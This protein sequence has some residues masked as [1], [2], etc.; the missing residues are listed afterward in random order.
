MCRVALVLAVWLVSSSG[1]L[2]IAAGAEA[3]EELLIGWQGETYRPKDENDKLEGA[4]VKPSSPDDS[5]DSER[6]IETI[7]W[8]PRAFLFHNFLSLDEVNHIVKLV[9]DR[10]ARSSVVDTETGH[11]KLDPIRTS[12]GSS[13]G[14]GQDAVIAAIETRMA[15]W[16]RL[17]PSH[18]EPIQVL[19]YQDGQKYGA[20]WDW[21]DDPIHKQ[22]NG[23]NRVATILMYLGDVLEGGETSFP[24]AIPINRTKQSLGSLS[25]CAAR[26]NLAV[27][28]HKGDAVLFW[29]ILPDGITVDRKALH[30]SCPIIKGTKWTATKWIHNRPYGET[31]D[32][33]QKA[34]ECLD[35]NHQCSQ[36][37]KEGKCDSDAANMLGLMGKCRL[38]CQDCVQCPRNDVIC[39]RQN[40]RSMR[41]QRQKGDQDIQ[42]ALKSAGKALH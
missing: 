7:S 27:R 13:I 28:P 39:L 3:K 21:F 12:Y 31:Y 6:W 24:L 36:W 26:G 40:M 29:D 2:G 34:A 37:A 1:L 35:R 16:T 11:H 18:G 23:E 17:P 10:V 41:V 22:G 42:N 19:R 5:G 20:H 15:E 33:L 25:E 14:R 8:K 32:P 9:E 4:V 30:A 38:S